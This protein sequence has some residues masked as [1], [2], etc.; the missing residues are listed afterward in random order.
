[1][2]PKRKTTT[3]KRKTQ[4]RKT[5]K[6]KTSRR[7]R[8]Y[9][10]G[11][12]ENKYVLIQDF[13]GEGGL[14]SEGICANPRA[15]D[16]LKE[17]FRTHPEQ[18]IVKGLVTNTNPQM[19]DFIEN[20]YTYQQ[21]DLTEEDQNNLS[22]NSA[23]WSFLKKHPEWIKYDKLAANSNSDALTMAIQNVQT[24]DDYYYSFYNSLSKNTNPAAFNYLQTQ[25]SANPDIE[26]FFNYYQLFTNQNSNIVMF[27]FNIVKNKH[28]Q[29]MELTDDQKA[30]NHCE[31][32]T[33]VNWLMDHPDIHDYKKMS[34]NKNQRVVDLLLQDPT[35]IVFPHFFKNENDRA[36]EYVKQNKDVLLSQQTIQNPDASDYYFPLCENKNPKIFDFLFL[37]YHV[38]YFIMSNHDLL[39]TITKNPIIFK[40]SPINDPYDKIQNIPTPP[41]MI[42][43][44]S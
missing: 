13:L 42:T 38:F 21:F 2:P 27:A 19:A 43:K 39:L 30:I 11:F 8:R 22:E 20:Y 17:M 23:L 26:E 15:I 4:K 28:E 44:Y 31:D 16:Y 36:I 9:H 12:S 41:H 37:Q 18:L 35:R 24:G 1:M 7:S 5:Q 25:Y 34:E 10:G 14:D 33:V 6:R 40:E 3:R 29:N 32:N